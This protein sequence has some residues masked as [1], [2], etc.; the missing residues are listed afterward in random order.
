MNKLLS[1]LLSP[2]FYISFYLVLLVFH[3]VQWICYNLMGYN[4]HKR[5]VDL[6]NAMLVACYHIMGTRVTFKNSYNLPEGQTILF[7]SNHQSLFDIPALI[8]FLRAYKPKFVSKKELAGAFPSV[9]YNLSTSGA[10]LVDRTDAVQALAEIERLGNFIHKNKFSAIL[11]PEGNRSKNGLIKPFKYRGFAKLLACNPQALIVPIA[12]NNAWKIQKYGKFP[13][14]FGENVSWK[15]L[16]PIEQKGKNM[17]ELIHAAENS[18][19]T[20]LGQ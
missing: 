2:L 4:A 6:L 12:I 20:E 15:V 7:I 3:P 18:I 10:A 14:S 1:Y 11:F 5:S 19:R 9:G 8:W 13:I 17:E 16:E